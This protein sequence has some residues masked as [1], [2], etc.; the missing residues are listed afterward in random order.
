M[1]LFAL[2]TAVALAQSPQISVSVRGTPAQPGSVLEFTVHAAEGLHDPQ[3]T[4]FGRPLVFMADRE[5]RTWRAVAGVD[6][7][8]PAGV[9]AFRI[10]FA[11]PDGRAITTTGAIDVL[12]R[13]FAT[14]R[15]RVANQ[16][17]DP[18]PAELDRIRADSARLEAI[19]ATVTVPDRFGPFAAPL[20]GVPASNFG[21][22]SVFNGEPRA[23]HAGADFRGAAGTPIAAPGAGRVVL[24][25]PLF[26]TGNTVVIDHG[27]GIY[28][29]LAHLSRLDVRAG[30]AVDRGTIVGLLGATGRVTGP[31][32]HWGV[33]LGEARVDPQRL[34]ALLGPAHSGK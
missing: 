3:G 4:A 10:Q 21:T 11:S 1:R 31:H 14:R 16:F 8:Q 25:E 5:P 33:R 13:T 18:S 30:D 26:F 15:L 17:V 29:L 19:F 22:R 7:A 9:A 34:L 32:L 20:P 28:S 24:A 12:P 23:P 27:R 6:V 2:L